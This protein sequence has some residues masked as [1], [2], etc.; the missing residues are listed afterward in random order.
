[1]KTALSRV[2]SC[3][4]AQTTWPKEVE[5]AGNLEVERRVWSHL[6]PDFLILLIGF[7]VSA[8]F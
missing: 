8:N 2:S 4:L 1:M 3:G 5:Y 7:A 6:N